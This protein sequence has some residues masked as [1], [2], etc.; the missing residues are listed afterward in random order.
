MSFKKLRPWIIGGLITLAILVGIAGPFLK[1]FYEFA[2]TESVKGYWVGLHDFE[3]KN[4]RFPKD[5]EVLGAFF[6]ETSEQLKKEPVEYVPPR[7][8]NS[9][10]VILWC[11]KTTLFG[12]RIGITESGTLVKK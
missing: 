5:D 1:R 7:D 10:E 6:H 2:I 12:T 3:T 9:D 8:T 4:G 11:K